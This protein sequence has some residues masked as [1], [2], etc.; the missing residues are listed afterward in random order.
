MA[1]TNFTLLTNEQKTVW[2]RD[3]WRT[4]RQTSFIMQRA[5]TGMNNVIQRVKELTKSEKG[6]RAVITLVPDLVGDGSMGDAEIEGKEE[7]A[8]AYDR[9]IE[10]DQIRNA[11][12]LKGRMAD[13]GSVVN[14]RETSRDLLAFW[15]AD[16]TDQL[17]ALTASGVDYRHKTNG[18]LR[19]GFTHNGT[20]YAR[21]TA[22]APSGYAFTDLAFANEVAAPSAA[23]HFRWDA[24]AKELV[25][26]DTTAVTATDVI[27]Y[28]TLVELKAY[29]KDRRIKSLRSGDN[30]LYH[31]FL[32]PK[33]MAK[34]KLD[35][36]FLANLR[37]AGVRGSGNPLF[38]GALVTVD[39]LVIH[40]WVHSFNTIGATTGASANANTP[41]YKW[42]ANANVVGNR[43]LLLG[44]QALAY[45]DI[46]IPEWDER[47]HF[48][49]GA[50][51]GI[52][53]S[54]ICGFLKPDFHSP[55]DGSDQDFGIVACDVAM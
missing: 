34:L 51:P 4:A 24:S 16:R 30:E 8:K 42:G 46:N 44:G 41:G 10:I 36:D 6:T 22:V 18:A 35:G 7:E 48:D 38:S 21:D 17:A 20:A 2:S 11:N 28:R 5:G 32:H 1:E 14:F 49:Y 12:K 31:V 25:G 15:L 54:K 47:D 40:E 39:G 3:V 43:V 52:A 37:N 50:K 23:R 29:A 26:G 53:V 45:A 9:V 19:P 13:Q 33:C 27:S 55:T